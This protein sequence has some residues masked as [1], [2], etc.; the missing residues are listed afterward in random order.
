M[1]LKAVL[2]D[3]DG[4][5]VDVEPVRAKSMNDAIKHF[6]GTREYTMEDKIS[7]NGRRA[8]DNFDDIRR[9]WIGNTELSFAEFRKYQI[10]QH[11]KHLEEEGLL[12][13]PGVIELL[14]SLK[15]AEIKVAV[16]TSS[17]R[18]PS[19]KALLVSGL[20]GRFDVVVTGD[21]VE[22]GKPAPDIFLKAAKRLG[23]RPE[24][25][26]VVGDSVVDGLAAL[27]GNMKFVFKTSDPTIDIGLK[28]DM[29][30]SSMTELTVVKLKNL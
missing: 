16:G 25:C 8:I 14:D 6:G 15:A 7:H 21:D 29:I 28:P 2:F 23:V 1:I 24:N 20:A 17:A 9:N 10:A 30:V 18:V 27:A 22:N 12:P 13:L 19:D 11:L 26:V 5:L 4:V 3:Q